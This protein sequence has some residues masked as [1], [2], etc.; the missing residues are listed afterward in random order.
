MI[1]AITRISRRWPNHADSSLETV[2]LVASNEQ[3]FIG[4]TRSLLEYDSH[5]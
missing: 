4:V 5:T 2:A 3:S 1:D